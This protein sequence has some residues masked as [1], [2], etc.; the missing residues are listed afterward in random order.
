MKAYLNGNLGREDMLTVD[1][2]LQK[3]PSILDQ[4]LSEL[5]ELSLLPENI[6]HNSKNE[7]SISIQPTINIHTV[8]FTEYFIGYYEGILNEIEKQELSSFHSLN[9]KLEKEFKIYGSTLLVVDNTI[10]FPDKNSLLKRTRPAVPLFW[11]ISAAA[12]IL[13][14]VGLWLFW[15]TNIVENGISMGSFDSTAFTKQLKTNNFIVQESIQTTQ[16]GTLVYKKNQINN[17]VVTNNTVSR[18]QSIPVSIKNSNPVELDIAADNNQLALQS[19]PIVDTNNPLVASENPKKKGLL[20]K[21][22]SGE[23]VFIEDYVNATF[24][25]FKNNKEDEDKWVLK[26]ERDNKGKSK[27]VKFTSPIFSFKTRN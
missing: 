17:S 26:V 10:Q 7:L 27:K 2:F 22:F 3:N 9:P 4:Y 1:V 16:S 5:E 6:T 21:I 25:V 14:V 19:V 23:Q 8:N 12:S 18:D 24:S 20:N 15:P 11:S 13:I